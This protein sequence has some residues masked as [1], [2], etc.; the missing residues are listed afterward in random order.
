MDRRAGFEVNVL[1]Q[2]AETK[3]T[4]A[5]DVAAIHRLVTADETEDR[6]FAGAVSPYQSDVFSGINL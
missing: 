4:R 3:T 1:V 2:Q 6:A 5:H